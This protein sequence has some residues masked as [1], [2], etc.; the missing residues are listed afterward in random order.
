MLLF[1]PAV[2]VIFLIIETDVVW[3]WIIAAITPVWDSF[4]LHVK[5]KKHLFV[6]KIC[7]HLL[8]V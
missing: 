8:Q 1:L 5:K 4:M 6:T 7:F 2:G 3:L